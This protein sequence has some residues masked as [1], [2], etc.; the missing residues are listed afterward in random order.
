MSLKKRENIAPPNGKSPE[1]RDPT[2]SGELWEKLWSSGWSLNIMVKCL[3]KAPSSLP[4]RSPPFC[5]SD[6]LREET[7]SDLYY[8]AFFPALSLYM[9]NPEFCVQVLTHCVSKDN[10]FPSK[11]LSNESILGHFL[12][13]KNMQVKF[14]SLLYTHV[15]RLIDW[16][17]KT[18][19][20]WRCGEMVLAHGGRTLDYCNIIGLTISDVSQKNH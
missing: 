18:K 17:F 7:L 8:N 5:C 19:N 11:S 10:Q 9:D 14:G 2:W 3:P 12:F 4:P 6:P 15:L 13:Y 16:I 20:F 1:L